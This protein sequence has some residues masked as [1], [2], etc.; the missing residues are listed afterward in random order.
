VHAVHVFA[1]GTVA[2]LAAANFLSLCCGDRGWGYKGSDIFRII[3]GFSIQG[4][5]IAPAVKDSLPPSQRGRYGRS[6]LVV[7]GANGAISVGEPFLPENFQILH[8]YKD[9][10]V[11]SFM[12]DASAGYKQ[13]S[14]FFVTLAPNAAWADGRYCAFGRVT[15]GMDFLQLL[16]FAPVQPPSNYP[17]NRVQIVNAGCY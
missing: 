10:G 17:V 1:S 5:N 9:A 16:Q 14:R 6:G 3:S 7:R 15:K 8:S 11:V 4:G 13:D 2:P 12:R